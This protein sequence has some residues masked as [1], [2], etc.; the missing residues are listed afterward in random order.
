[1]KR[2]IKF[3]DKNFEEV[4]LVIGTIAMI[5]FIFFQVISRRFLNMSIAWSEELSRYIFIWS[6]WLGVPYAVIKGRHIRLTVIRDIVNDTGKFILD[7]LFF[8][9]SIAFFLYL[10]FHSVTLTSK[11]HEMNQLTPAMAIPKWLC[12]LALPFG[13]F[14]GCFRF[15]QYM[16]KRIQRFK[17]NPADNETFVLPEE[18]EV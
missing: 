6:V 15:L 2:V 7:M 11:I 8:I 9:V 1:M 18:D 13:S 3:L 17:I 10:G 14:L 4:L 16:L 12:Y 5:L